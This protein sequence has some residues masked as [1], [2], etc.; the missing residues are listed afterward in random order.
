M[1]A[2][3]CEHLVV[4]GKVVAIVNNSAH[5]AEGRR[6]SKATDPPPNV[7]GDK[8]FIVK[9]QRP[10]VHPRD[11]GQMTMLVYDQDRTLQ[12]HITATDNPQV[13]R[14]ALQLMP[15]GSSIS[16]VYCWAKRCADWQLSLCLDREVGTAPHW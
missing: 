8:A 2:T 9:L 15:F 4:D 6:P 5:S 1:T 7:H 11:E 3:F 16:K 14:E 10:L 13:W 12:G